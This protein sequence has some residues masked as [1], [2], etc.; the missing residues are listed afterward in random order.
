MRCSNCGNDYPISNSYCPKCGENNP[1]YESYKEEVTPSYVSKK[2]DE[3]YQNSTNYTYTPQNDS[4]KVEDETNYGLAVI[5]FII[6]LVGF[7]IAASLWS[8]KPNTASA[9]LQAAFWSIGLVIFV[10]LLF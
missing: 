1:S 2:P 6:P 7:I 9:C 5:S 8:T 10:N 4:T 3:T